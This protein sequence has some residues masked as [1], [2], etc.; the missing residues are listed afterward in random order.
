MEKFAGV[1]CSSGGVLIACQKCIC[2]ASDGSTAL[3]QVG[4]GDFFWDANGRNQFPK[5]AEDVDAQLT[6]YKQVR[7]TSG[8][9]CVHLNEPHAACCHAAPCLAVPAYMCDHVCF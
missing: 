8:L 3:W 5:V 9:F 1:P 6:K 2:A 4:E 7:P